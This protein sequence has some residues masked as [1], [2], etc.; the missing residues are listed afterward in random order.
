MSHSEGHVG[1][2]GISKFA[3]DISKIMLFNSS[4]DRHWRRKGAVTNL[5][6]GD[7]MIF[8]FKDRKGWYVIGKHSFF[9]MVLKK[10]FSNVSKLL[11]TE[12]N[13]ATILWTLDLT[14]NKYYI[15]R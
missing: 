2:I 10:E 14:Q 6:T 9:K 4:L 15:L 8:A 13:V 1:K 11:E 12:G 3:E 5:D 7:T